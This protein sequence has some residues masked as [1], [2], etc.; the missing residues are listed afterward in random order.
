MSLHDDFTA[1]LNS[2]GSFEKSRRAINLQHQQQQ[3]ACEL[4]ALD[5]LACSLCRLS[6]STATLA[7]A[8]VEKLRTIGE[9][10]AQRL[11]YLLEAIQPIEVDEDRCVVQLRSCPPHKD[12]DRTSYYEL[13]VR[14]GGEVSLCRYAKEPGGTRR[15]LAAQTT[16][17]VLLRL[18]GD[19]S[20]A[21]G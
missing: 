12:Q 16:R 1:A 9:A 21:A 7:D 17:E 15:E 6:V 20:E 4:E 14:R 10:L 5:K 11:T 19:L 8:P 13:L 18:V 3:I 2:L